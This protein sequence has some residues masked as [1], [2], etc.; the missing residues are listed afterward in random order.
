LLVK[1]TAQMRRG[2]SPCQ[3]M[4]RAILAIRQYV[5]PAPGPATTR[6]GPRGASMA[7]RCAGDGARVRLT[8]ELGDGRKIAAK[9]AR[10][11]SA[12]GIR[13]ASEARQ[14]STVSAGARQL[15]PV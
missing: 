6:T 4:S 13:A 5:L 2:S 10:R 12:G 15:V 1:V 9:R 8:L 7:S 3:A 11:Q 14:A